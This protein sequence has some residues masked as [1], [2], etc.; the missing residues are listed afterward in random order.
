MTVYK[1]KKYFAAIKLSGTGKFVWQT[2]QLDMASTTNTLAVDD[3]LSMCPAGFDV[4]SLIKLS[5]TIL[6]TYGS[7]E[8]KA[9][10]QIELIC[11]AQCKLHI[12]QFQVLSKDVMGS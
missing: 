3:L 8:I 12:F 1:G 9:V 11:E 5:C 2:L 10:G 4:T 6:H 7:G